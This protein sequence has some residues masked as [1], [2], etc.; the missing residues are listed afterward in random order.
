MK[1]NKKSRI[2][3]KDTELSSL[4]EKKNKSASANEQSL[5]GNSTTFKIDLNYTSSVEFS[6]DDLQEDDD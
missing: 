1:K 6:F 5:G 4:K 2:S 3:G